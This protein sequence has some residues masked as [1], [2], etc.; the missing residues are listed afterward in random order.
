MQPSYLVK[1]NESRHDRIAARTMAA[2]D[3]MIAQSESVSFYSV[4]KR[5]KVARSTLYRRDDLRRIVEKA[6]SGNF[7]PSS[8][9][10]NWKALAE[11]LEKELE[12]AKREIVAL[13]ELQVPASMHYAFISMENA[14]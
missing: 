2:I 1:S 4:S 3:E 9:E 13:R 10:A 5:A 11:D 6:R 7:A 12:A 8:E 14:A